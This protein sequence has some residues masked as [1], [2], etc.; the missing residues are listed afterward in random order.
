[1][2]G[3][4]FL[5]GTVFT[6]NDSD[7]NALSFFPDGHALATGS[8]NGC[9]RMYDLRADNEIA[10]Y[11]HD[12]MLALVTSLA[13]SPSGKFLFVGYDDCNFCQWDTLRAERTLIVAANDHRLSSLGV[14]PDG[15]ALCTA[16]WDGLLKIWS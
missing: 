10:M 1:M 2:S 12:D 5:P 14:A 4:D 9:V 6:G 16:S 3:R 13:F 15:T 11:V 8:E 7:V